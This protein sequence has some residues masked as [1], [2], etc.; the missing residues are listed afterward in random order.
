MI[1]SAK[2]RRNRKW[3]LYV[4][5]KSSD[6]VAYH[7]LYIEDEDVKCETKGHFNELEHNTI[8]EAY[9]KL[10]DEVYGLQVGD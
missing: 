2:M 5:Q 4:R 1:S 10:L 8:M 9:N 7:S 3:I 6:S